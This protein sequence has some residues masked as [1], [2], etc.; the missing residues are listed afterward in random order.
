M[1]IIDCHVWHVTRHKDPRGRDH[2]VNALKLLWEQFAAT[3]QEE[4]MMLTVETSHA[5]CFEEVCAD[6]ESVKVVEAGLLQGLSDDA[7][8]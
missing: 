2:V 8:A 7:G 4:V 1:Y 3:T 6:V 5:H